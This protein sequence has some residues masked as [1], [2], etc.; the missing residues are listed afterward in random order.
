[1]RAAHTALITFTAKALYSGAGAKFTKSS[2]ASTTS[3]CR[4]D[5]PRSP[6]ATICTPGSPSRRR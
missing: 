6:V 1:M 3:D 4:E 2:A 5:V